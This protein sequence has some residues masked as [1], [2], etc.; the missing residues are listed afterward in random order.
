M[1]GNRPPRHLSAA[2]YSKCNFKIKKKVKRLSGKNALKCRIIDGEAHADLEK[3]LIDTISS[4]GILCGSSESPTYA[5]AE[6]QRHIVGDRVERRSG[7]QVA[8][9]F[10]KRGRR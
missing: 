4:Y 8:Q 1:H 9:T 7:T 3:V 10:N 6:C 2:F 5:D